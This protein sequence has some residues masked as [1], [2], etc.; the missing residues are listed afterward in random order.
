MKMTRIHKIVLAVVLLA[1]LVTAVAAAAPMATI[2]FKAQETHMLICQGD[3]FIIVP[4]GDTQ[5]EV[6]CRVWVSPGSA[7]IKR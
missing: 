6:T 3:E 7:P 5:M 2:V 1:M 4:I